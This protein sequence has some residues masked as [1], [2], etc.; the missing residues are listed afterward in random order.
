MLTPS[1]IDKHGPL[2]RWGDAKRLIASEVNVGN[3]ITRRSKTV[4][5]DYEAATAVMESAEKMFVKQLGSLNAAQAKLAEAAKSTSSNVRK[6][7]NE[8]QEGVQRVEKAANFDRFERQVAVL[9]R[10]AAALSVLAELER[11][12]KLARLIAAV[13]ADRPQG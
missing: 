2:Y 8:I 11:D 12:G 4:S 7:A 5:T 10:A 1:K 13:S 9:E 3:P 6:A